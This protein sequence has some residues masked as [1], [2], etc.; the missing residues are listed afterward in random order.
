[1]A[2]CR[3]LLKGGLDRTLHEP[4]PAD[5]DRL[6]HFGRSVRALDLDPVD[7]GVLRGVR[8]D[9]LPAERAPAARAGI[10]LRPR[11]ED[12]GHHCYVSLVSEKA[13]GCCDGNGKLM[14]RQATKEGAVAKRNATI[15]RRAHKAC[16]ISPER[17]LR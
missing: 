13:Y 7:A 4:A 17:G 2:W 16:T 5:R 15:R 11:L 3:C 8:V 14:G 12:N 6:A 10:L 9:H 1:M